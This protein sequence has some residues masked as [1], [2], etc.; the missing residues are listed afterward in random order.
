LRYRA[1]VDYGRII[2]DCAIRS[3]SDRKRIRANCDRDDRVAVVNICK[4]SQSAARVERKLRVWVVLRRSSIRYRCIGCIV[5]F[6][7]FGAERNFPY[8]EMAVA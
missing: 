3:Q 8:Y 7:L 5:D 1:C 2:R 6:R 4:K